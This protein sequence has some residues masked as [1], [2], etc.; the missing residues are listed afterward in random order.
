MVST[1][2]NGHG[3]GFYSTGTDVAIIGGGVVGLLSA[4]RMRE[5]GIEYRIIERSTDFGGTWHTHSNN[6][7]TLQES[8]GVFRTS[9]TIS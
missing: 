4:M 6:H 1:T 8:C 5:R 7:S 3:E 9:K 2:V